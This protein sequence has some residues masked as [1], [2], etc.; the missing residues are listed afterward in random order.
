MDNMSIRD[1]DNAELEEDYDS[2]QLT[3]LRIWSVRIKDLSSLVAALISRMET[4]ALCIPEEPS[5]VAKG[6]QEG[7]L[8]A[9]VFSIRP[10]TAGAKF[11]VCFIFGDKK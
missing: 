2:E 3:T 9:A 6:M 1:T 7:K 5:S 11:Q 10:I 8:R 4:N